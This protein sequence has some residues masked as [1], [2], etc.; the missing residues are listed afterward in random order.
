MH[1]TCKTGRGT[2]VNIKSNS[3]ILCH[4]ISDHKLR[5]SLKP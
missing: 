1:P 3:D 2:K 5:K 4:L